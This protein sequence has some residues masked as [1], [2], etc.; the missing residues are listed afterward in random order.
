MEIK[1]IPLSLVTPSPM[2]PRKTFDEEE[3]KELADN[4]EKQGLLQPITVRPIQEK[5]KFTVM[6]GNADFHPEYEL[7]CGER[8]FRAFKKLCEKWEVMDVVSPKGYSYN[9][10]SDIPAIVREMNDD[11][12]FDAMIT[13]NLQRTDVDPME[14]A[15][16]FGEL[17]KKGKSAEEIAKRF[18]K[19]I[20][21]VQDRVKLNNLIPELMLAVKDEKMS[22]VAAMMI[23]KLDEK[24]QIGYYKSYGANVSGFSKSTAESYLR[25]IFMNIK[26]TPWNESNK[27]SD[28]EFAGGCGKSCSECEFNTANHGCLFWEMKCDDEGRCTNREMFAKK[29]T[30]FVLSFLEKYRKNLIA[31]GEPLES[32]KMVIIDV[33]DYCTPATKRLKESIY[34]NIKDAGF[35][36]VQSETIFEGKCWYKSNDERLKTKQKQ[37]KVY[38]CL[39]IFNYDNIVL[40]EE[41]QFFKGGSRDSVEDKLSENLPATSSQSVEAMQLVQKRN[42]IREIAVEKL[43]EKNR[44]LADSL[45]IAKRKGELSDA[46]QLAFDI[47]I[48]TLCGKDMLKKYGH[49]G[50]G[51]PT[52][53]SFIDIVKQNRADRALWIREFIRT[54]ISSSDINYNG[55]YQYCAGEVLKEWMPKEEKEIVDAISKK[56]GKDLEKN[57]EKLKELGYDT[58]GK[59]LPKP[60]NPEKEEFSEKVVKETVKPAG[61]MKQFREM[62]RNHKDAILLFRIGDFYECFNEDAI[63]IAELLN[64]TKIMGKRDGQQV[65]IAGFPHHALDTYVPKL[66]RAGKRVAICEQLEKPMKNK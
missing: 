21:F 51:K 63:E 32:G 45:K 33:N 35:E 29:H 30:A 39:R 61:L 65:Q 27:K 6:D 9:K 25:S 15:F 19:S 22:L 59:L 24:D 17:I 3:L 55:L 23:A 11:D 1:Q 16:A 26:K 64:L 46:E 52:D 2:N 48:F 44:A 18:G 20:R 57:A 8:R 66:I 42:R 50:Y 60:N 41:W 36:V 38:R 4:I 49:E 7:I 28:K 40:Q 5:R 37:G 31:A 12:A 54:I 10:F 13:E 58:N 47:I 62:K 53:R 34:K 14:E 56:L 43:T